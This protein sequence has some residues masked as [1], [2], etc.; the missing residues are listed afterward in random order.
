MNKSIL[1]LS[2]STNENGITRRLFSLFQTL[3]GT[4]QSGKQEV[5]LV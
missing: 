3:G 5:A 2:S 1:Y 4:F